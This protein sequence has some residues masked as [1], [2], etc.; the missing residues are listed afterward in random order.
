MNMRW[1]VLDKFRKHKIVIA[2]DK[3]F[4]YR[5]CRACASS[6][7]S[8]NS[9]TCGAS[10]TIATS[11][12]CAST[13]ATPPA[14][15]AHRL[16]AVH[17]RPGGVRPRSPL[18]SL[19]LLLPRPGHRTPRQGPLHQMPRGTL[20]PRRVRNQRERLVPSLELQPTL[21]RSL[22]R[23][24]QPIRGQLGA[25]EGSLIIIEAIPTHTTHTT[26]TTQLP[27]ITYWDQ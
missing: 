3:T 26:H 11:I 7:T 14:S 13:I 18:P 27:H 5:C 9:R 25:Q 24:A 16:P 10:P 1:P 17:R 23:R 12:A 6:A 21:P 22:R 19:R 4:R 8:S 2:V 15:P 20:R